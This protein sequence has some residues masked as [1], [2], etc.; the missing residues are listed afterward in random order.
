MNFAFLG[1]VIPEEQVERVAKLSKHNMADAAIAL[2]W[3]LYDG[4]CQ[5]LQAG[6]KLINIMPLGSYPQYY[7]RP[8]VKKE[9]FSTRFCKDN[10]NVGFCNVKLIKNYSQPKKL[11]REL[12]KWCREST[13]NRFVFLY[14]LSHVLLSALEAAKKEFPDLRACAIV[15]D[16]PN[17]SSLSARSGVLER[18]FEKHASNRSYVGL[19]A[20]DA[21]V[22][23]TR[24][25]ADYMKIT[26]PFCVVEGISTR[27]EQEPE[28]MPL[29]GETKKI[30]YSGTLHER[31]G[32][33]NLLRAFE[34]LPDKDLELI[35]CGVG[36]SEDRIKEAAERDPR[37]HFLGRCA[38][39]EVLELQKQAT[40]L[41]NPRQNNEEFTKYSFPSKNLEY[42]SSGRPLVAYKLDGIPDEYDDFIYYVEND[43]IEA[44][45][46]RLREICRKPAEEIERH[47]REAYFYVQEHKNEIEQ[48]KIILQ[49]LTEHKLLC[50]NE[51]SERETT[52]GTI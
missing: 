37:I 15:A 18:L 31:F 39:S 52:N 10:I 23:L 41:V 17:M 35:L 47:C 8:F 45:A 33:L 24:Q 26:Q 2:Q 30:L 6:V 51:K 21:F 40:V 11:K 46:E 36:D 38:R 42:L 32:V 43:S 1:R 19:G 29:A 14:T 20:V 13:E 12:I 5:N 49:M 28:F 22:L 44:L 34:T 48:T 3:H 16:L 9:Q 4:L 50:T 27:H 7:Q 25:M